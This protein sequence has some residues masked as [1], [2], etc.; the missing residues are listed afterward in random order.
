MR[1]DT[2]KFLAGGEAIRRRLCLEQAA[3]GRA[4]VSPRSTVGVPSRMLVAGSS[5]PRPAG[6]MS[7]TSGSV[8]SYLA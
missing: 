5:V 4:L 6:S 2:S 7:H 8:R 1:S 3:G